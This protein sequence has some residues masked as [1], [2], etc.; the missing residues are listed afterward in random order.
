MRLRAWGDET[1]PAVVLLHGLRGFSGT[2]RGLAQH[3]SGSFHLIALDQRGR[4]ESDW[5]PGHNYYTDA[6]LAD[7]VSVVDGLKLDRFSLIGHSM[8]GT[9]SYVFASLHPERLDA[10]IIE[11]IAPGASIQGEGAERIKAEM[12]ALPLDF[13][14]WDE[15]RA[16]WRKARPSVGDE[17][18]EQRLAESLRESADGRV[19]WQYDARGISET[20]LH[21]DP[22]RVVDLW[23]VIDRIQTPTLV[24]RGERSDFCAMPSVEEMMRRNPNIRSTTVAGASHYVHDDAPDVFNQEVKRFLAD[25]VRP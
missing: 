6:Y 12:A 15:A 21:P 10:L 8:G 22:E 13:A 20:R 14:S 3:L 25:K 5:D 4:G 11:D 7:L 16:Y 1:A 24:I 17:A 23:P 19:V 9:T 2:W 18:L